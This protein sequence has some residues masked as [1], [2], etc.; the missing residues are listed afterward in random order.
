[1][2]PDPLPM[3]RKLCLALP[4][5]REVEAWGAPTFRVKTIFATYSDGSQSVRGRRSTW[6]KAL[7][8]NQEI[9]VRRDPARFFVPPYVGAKGWVGVF[10]DEPPPDW[11]EL[12][13]LL[14]DA[15]KMSVPK[16]LLA[17]HP[18]APE[19]REDS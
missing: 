12:R 18:E 10:L 15:W 5:A 14:W 2:A 3:L 9:L 7:P 8:V 6:V 1:M 13:I 11:E 17:E 4:E 16:R 19:L